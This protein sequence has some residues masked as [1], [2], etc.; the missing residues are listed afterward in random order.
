MPGLVQP[1]AGHPRLA[2]NKQGVHP[3]QQHDGPG[4]NQPGGVDGRDKPGRD[5][6]RDATDRT[7]L[8]PRGR[9][10]GRA[11]PSIVSAWTEK[12]SRASVHAARLVQPA[13]R[14]SAAKP[15]TVYL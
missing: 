15:S 5:V 8:R 1:C 12:Y 4:H 13:P 2:G 6:L 7:M 3:G 14:A 11:A 9:P 10:Y